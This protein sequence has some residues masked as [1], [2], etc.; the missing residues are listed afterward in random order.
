VAPKGADSS[1]VGHPLGL[2]IGKPNHRRIVSKL[3]ERARE[4]YKVVLEEDHDGR[5]TVDADATARLRAAAVSPSD[6]G[7]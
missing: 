4:V 7:P 5:Y 6:G 2:P 3:V 1:P